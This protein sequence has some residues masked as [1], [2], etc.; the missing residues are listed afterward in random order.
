MLT[1]LTRGD[2]REAI[3]FLGKAMEADAGWLRRIRPRDL[4]GSAEEFERTLKAVEDRSREEPPDP[5]AKVLL[6]YLQFHEKGVEAARQLLAEA[7]AVRPELPVAQAFRG[8]LDR[9]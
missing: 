1:C 6:A 4:F 8:A 5:E 9:P 2:V 3:L 7:V